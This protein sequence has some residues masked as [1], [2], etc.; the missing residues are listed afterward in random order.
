MNGNDLIGHYE[1]FN[2]WAEVDPILLMRGIS[3]RLEDL[4]DKT[5]GL[6]AADYKVASSPT[7][8]VIERKLRERFPLL[9][10]NWFRFP[11]QI[12]VTG[13]EHKGRF[14]E[15]IKQI[16]AAITGLGD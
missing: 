6:F 5:I 12:E 11:R 10:L 4:R 9:K 8:A 13:T 3:P 16:D 7:L 2:P 15:W 14:E 1:V